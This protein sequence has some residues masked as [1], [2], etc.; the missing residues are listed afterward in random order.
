MTLGAVHKLSTQRDEARIFYLLKIFL[1][2]KALCYGKTVSEGGQ[3]RTFIQIFSCPPNLIG[4]HCFV[5]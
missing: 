1:L 2:I 3:K 5:K 4:T